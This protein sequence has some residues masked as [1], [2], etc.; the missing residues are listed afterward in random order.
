MRDMP[1]LLFW[2]QTQDH[3][4]GQIVALFINFVA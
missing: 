1:H 4:I 3:K 2:E